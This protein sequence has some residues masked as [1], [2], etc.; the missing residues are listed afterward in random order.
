MLTKILPGRHKEALPRWRDALK[1]LEALHESCANREYISALGEYGMCCMDAGDPHT[2]EEA[3]NRAVQLF[4]DPA[5]MDSEFLLE[6][7]RALCDILLCR[8]VVRS[9]LGNYAGAVDSYDKVNPN[10]T[11][12]LKQKLNSKLVHRPAR[13]PLRQTFPRNCIRTYQQGPCSYAARKRH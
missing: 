12:N 1:F 11:K 7:G 5:M 2:G 10:D 13:A 9:A 4:K 8:G 6:D 3:L